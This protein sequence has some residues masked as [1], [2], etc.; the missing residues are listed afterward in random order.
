M[1]V[2]VLRSFPFSRDGVTS[3]RA[4][5]DTEA[6]IPNDLVAGLVAAGYVAAIAEPGIRA[7]KLGDE[8]AL[9]A[10]QLPPKRRRRS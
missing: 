3:E 1:R 7:D 10:E 2:L 4:V 8:L 6:D 9:V 5:A